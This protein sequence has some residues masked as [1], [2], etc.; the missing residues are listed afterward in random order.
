MRSIDSH[1]FIFR[2]YE[3]QYYYKYGVNKLL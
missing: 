1:F 3:S 2:T